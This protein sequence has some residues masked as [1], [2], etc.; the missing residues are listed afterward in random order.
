MALDR[1]SVDYL[2]LLLLCL[3]LLSCLDLGIAHQPHSHSH[4]HSGFCASD[5]N[6]H[7]D[8][9]HHH[10]D[11]AH[12]HKDKIDGRSKLPEELAEEEDM[13]LYGFGL[14]H[15]HHH[16]DTTELSGLGLWLNALGCSFLVSM[17]SLVCLII[18]P[19][20]FVQGKPSKAVVDS[21]AL[22]GAGAMLGDAFLHQLP[23]AFGGEL[24]HSHD[25]HGHSHSHDNHGEHDH[26]ASSGHGH[27]HSLADLSV[28]ISILG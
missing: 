9:H 12:D 6:H 23:H 25:N 8:D 11:H 14:P 5:A 15:H 22:F 13:K 18:L 10:H 2:A 20:I 1:K 24:S 28:G 3:A 4:S 21:L 17:A 27:S 26:H 19:I 16:H 7:C